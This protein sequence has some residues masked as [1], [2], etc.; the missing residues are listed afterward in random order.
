V[1][2]PLSLLSVSSVLGILSSVALIAVVLI[3][4]FHKKEAPG[5]LWEPA[6]TSFGV[7][8]VTKLGVSFGLFM[9]GF[10][11]HSVIPSLARDM[12]NPA[13]FDEMIDLAFLIST[14]I[15]A[16]IGGAGYAMF[17]NNVSEEFS[18]D[19]LGVPGYNAA[20]NKAALWLLVISPLSKFGLVSRPLNG[21]VE[22]LLGL[23]RTPPPASPEAG[24]SKTVSTSR[25]QNQAFKE[26]CIAI[27]R[28]LL[29]LLA[30]GVSILVPEFS[31]MMGFLGSFAAFLLCVIGPVSAK[32]A[33]NGR[34]G[35]WDAFVLSVAIVMAVFGTFSVWYDT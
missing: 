21:T 2:L 10:S 35:K 11:G 34:C 7:E 15:Y 26:A 19:L 28:T 14:L 32:I 23:D 9:A 1:F 13:Q 20:L 29:A 18:Q 31:A 6:P 16:I 33:V 25:F 27:E 12:Q 30:V 17:G 3:D 4:G 24:S 22:A 8:S 5:S